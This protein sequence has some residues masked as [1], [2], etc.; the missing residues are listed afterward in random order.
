MISSALLNL[1]VSVVGIGLLA[2]VV[3][4]AHHVADGRLEETP[5]T[6]ATE[7]GTRYELERAA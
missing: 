4:S 2:M 6:P 3:R 5:T 7:L 1:I